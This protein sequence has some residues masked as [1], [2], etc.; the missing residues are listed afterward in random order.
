MKNNFA[1]LVPAGRR[2]SGKAGAG[3]SRPQAEGEL[4]DNGE[5]FS[6]VLNASQDS[7]F[8]KDRSFRYRQ[9]S[10]SMERLFGIKAS[11][12]IGKSDE[13]LFGKEAGKKIRERDSQVLKGDVMENEQTM[14]TKDI[15]RTFRVVKAPIYDSRD[16]IVGI[17]GIARDITE[18][19]ELEVKIHSYQGQ[20]RSLAS[21]LSLIEE[22][23]RQQIAT[24]L[25]D[26]IG[27]NLALSKIKLGALRDLAPSPA[28]T[29]KVDEIRKLIEQTIEY[30]RTLVFELTPALL[31]DL[32]LEG[33]VEWLTE[34]FEEQHGISFDFRNDGQPK[35]VD[36]STRIFLFQAVR[37]L[38]INVIKHS[39]A[40]KATVSIRGN[41]TCIQITVDDDGVGLDASKT[42]SQLK[43]TRGFGIFS[44]RER[45]RLL[46]GRL[47]I[48]SDPHFG[49]RVTLVAPLKVE[50]KNKTGK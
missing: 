40:R 7:I 22:R 18:R 13:E 5:T 19:I 17:C 1:Q 32:G 46:G 33:A 34:R 39:H 23:E 45:L 25:H 4:E 47:E 49:T 8:T 36:N 24:D 21:D 30:A 44:I 38:M 35:P 9:I 27:Q 43:R 29:Q 42:G 6:A 20:L 26:H 3:R 31:F 11:E 48:K 50:N 10:P 12:W 14:M 15:P 28:L 2:K 16:E 37:E 41:D